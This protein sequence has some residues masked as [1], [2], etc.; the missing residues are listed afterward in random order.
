[1]HPLFMALYPVSDV[2]VHVKCAIGSPF[3]QQPWFPRSAE[4][5]NTQI[6]P[7]YEILFVSVLN[8]SRALSAPLYCFLSLYLVCEGEVCL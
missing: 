7:S 1:M 4:N 5:I 2:F 8:P 3:P 6:S